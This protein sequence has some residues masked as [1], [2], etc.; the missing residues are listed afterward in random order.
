MRDKRPISRIV[1]MVI[2]SF[3]ERSERSFIFQRE[4]AVFQS[5]D[6]LSCVHQY[7][8]MACHDT[9]GLCTQAGLAQAHGKKAF[10]Q[11]VLHFFFGEIALWTNQH[12]DALAALY[13]VS[14]FA[15][16]VLVAVGDEALLLCVI[17][18]EGLKIGQGIQPR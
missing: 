16:V 9:G 12:A 1:S 2:Q 14:Q 6:G 18:N 10:C 11:R 5:F 3:S 8:R 15:L 17:G 13:L 7:R 4:S